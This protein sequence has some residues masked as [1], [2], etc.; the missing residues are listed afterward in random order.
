MIIYKAENK[1][2]GKVYIG[3]TIQGLND[4][5]GDHFRK[6]FVHR[7]KGIFQSAIRKYGINGFDW[8]IIDHAKTRS[9][10]NKKEIYWIKHYKSTDK[11]HGYNS[12][13]GGNQPIFTEEIKKK[14]GD[15]QRGMK[16]TDEFKKKISNAT[17]GEK[18]P[19][20]GKRHSKE[21]KK[22][23]GIK[24]IGRKLTKEHI[25]KCIHKG[26][27]NGMS[28]L[29]EYQVIEIKT[30]LKN[31]ERICDIGKIMDVK[32]SL[33]KNIKYENTWKHIII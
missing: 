4:R 11:E 9:G 6:A 16:R 22:K 28:V 1:T 26:E 8:K 15:S 33:I 12:T 32:Q 13:F 25:E 18:N 14:I 27:S 21:S 20:Y 24:N 2:N 3:Q 5:I 29:K 30:R 31:K 10:L 19:F 7:I 23:C 17:K